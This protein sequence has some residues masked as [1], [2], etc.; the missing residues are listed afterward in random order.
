MTTSIR[1]LEIERVRSE[2]RHAALEGLSRQSNPYGTYDCNRYQWFVGYDD[3]KE[4]SE[5]NHILEDLW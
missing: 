5:I 2:G 3:G 4:E 1:A